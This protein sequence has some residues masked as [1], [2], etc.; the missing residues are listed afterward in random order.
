MKYY[1][2][3]RFTNRSQTSD[4]LPCK[5]HPTTGKLMLFTSEK[6]AYEFIKA[7]GWDN[8]LF[9]TYPDEFDKKVTGRYIIDP[10]LPKSE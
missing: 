6:K 7:C 1:R 5:K 4:K 8:G 9:G 2:I 10:E 3:I